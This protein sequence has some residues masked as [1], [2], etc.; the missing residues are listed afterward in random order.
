MAS[1]RRAYFGAVLA[2]SLVVCATADRPVWATETGATQWALGVQTVVPAIL[3]AAGETAYYHYTLYYHADRFTD[4]SGNVLIPGFNASV[5]ANAGRIVHTW[6]RKLGPLNMSS[7]II[8]AGSYVGVETGVQLAPGLPLKDS[9]F[10]LTYLYVTPLY[11]TY[12][13]P[14]LHLLWGGS[15]YIPIGY[16]SAQDLANPS[17][18]YYSFHQEIAI[19]YFPMKTLEFSAQAGITFNAENPTTDYQ[20]GAIFD[21]DWGINWAPIA[22]MPNLFFGITGFYATQFTD[23]EINNVKVGPD[24]F[25]L[26]KIALGPQ[27]IYYFSKKAGIAFKYQREFE[28]KNGPEGDRFWMQFVVPVD[29]K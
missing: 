25:R 9:T 18:N 27:V 16:F 26:E 8:L 23:D 10:G 11:L 12:N 21:V 6:E 3:P 15:V 4:G 2:I 24:G 14:K 20:S 7:G 17:L 5:F 28:T 29:H 13:T 19:T 22:S 1:K